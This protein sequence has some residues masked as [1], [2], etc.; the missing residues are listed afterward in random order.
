MSGSVI[1]V[2]CDIAGESDPYLETLPIPDVATEFRANLGLS[3][4]CAIAWDSCPPNVNFR[5]LT[6]ASLASCFRGEASRP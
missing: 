1:L 4:Q 5:P 3:H 2:A 6:F